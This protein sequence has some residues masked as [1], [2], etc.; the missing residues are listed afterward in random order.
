MVEKPEYMAL[1]NPVP[2]LPESEQRE[3]LAKF[4]PTEWFVVGK[5]GEYDQFIGLVR[6][7]RVVLVAYP[8]MLA[9]QV[10]DKWGRRDSMVALKVAIHKRHSR[11]E[12]AEGNSSDRNWRTMRAGGEKMCSRIAQGRKSA[13]NAK[14]GANRWDDKP[15]MTPQIK[16]AMKEE[17]FVIEG[18]RTVDDAVKAI[19]RK[20]R[21]LAPGRTVLYREFG[22]PVMKKR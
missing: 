12:D 16:A 20:F 15:G 13:L 17:W 5:D 6:P 19:K 21:K 18:K 14:R 7:P 2:A 10:G 8:A 1:V 22:D 3:M 11:V 4:Q 9:E